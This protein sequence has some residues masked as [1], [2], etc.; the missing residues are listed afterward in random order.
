MR[1]TTTSEASTR[2]LRKK[3]FF[4]L[5]A[6]LMVL[7]LCLTSAIWITLFGQ[8][9]RAEN[10][11]LA[12]NAEI[13]S[14]AIAEWCRRAKDIGKQITSRTMIRLELEKYNHGLVNLQQL[15]QFTRP[16]LQDAMHLSP[17]VLGILRLDA[18]NQV[19]T[20]C[21]YGSLLSFSGQ[22]ISDYVQP[23]ISLSEPLMLKGHPSILVC[24]PI[25]NRTGERQGTD[26]VI[27]TLDMLKKLVASSEELGKTSETLVGYRSKDAISLLFPLQVQDGRDN[28][29]A[30]S[31]LLS[32]AK[33][34]ILKAIEGRS[35]LVHTATTAMAY[36]PIAESDWGLVITQN[37][38]EL[39]W[40]LYQKMVIISGLSFLIYAT[41]LL[42]FWFATNPLAD[43]ILLHADELEKRIQEKTESLEREISEREKAEKEKEK[44]IA[45]LRE[46]MQKI[47]TLSGMLPI[48]AHCK[49]VR[50]DKGYWNQIESYIGSHSEIEFSHSICRECAQKLYPGLGIIG[51]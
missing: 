34:Q 50:D 38:K 49:K 47:K 15:S 23:R 51:D 18:K 29:P 9:K 22:T 30:P 11:S 16:K 8:L 2:R 44:N 33:E 46:A 12:H 13:R 24:A 42:G 19:V 48:C 4:Y 41:I 3:L 45:E 35:G 39:Y 25:M 17:E 40:P 37:K 14:I 6:A 20:G 1:T 43:K 36:S 10:S 31:T 7:V 5:A 27:F 32:V 26:L 21:G 28:A